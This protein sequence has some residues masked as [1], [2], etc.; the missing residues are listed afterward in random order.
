MLKPFA[1]AFI[2]KVI[3]FPGDRGP[4]VNT[5]PRSSRQTYLKPWWLIT[6][7]KI[8]LQSQ[9]E[10]VCLGT[11]MVTRFNLFLG[12]FSAK[13]MTWFAFYEGAVRGLLSDKNTPTST[14]DKYLRYETLLMT[15]QKRQLTKGNLEA[16][17][18]SWPGRNTNCG[19]F[20]VMTF[21]ENIDNTHTGGGTEVPITN[22]KFH[23]WSMAIRLPWITEFYI[24]QRKT[25]KWN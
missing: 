2:C 24:L 14:K 11:D 20:P 22:Q 19:K 3:L 5:K 18:L 6:V 16:L 15:K 1:R 13:G 8:N 4:L 10:V 23:T 9:T 12:V 7:T 21:L 25:A 17:Y